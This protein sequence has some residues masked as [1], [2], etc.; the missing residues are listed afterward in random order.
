MKKKADEKLTKRIVDKARRSSD[1]YNC[2]KEIT[3][4]S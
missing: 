4:I 1:Y 3:V 2:N